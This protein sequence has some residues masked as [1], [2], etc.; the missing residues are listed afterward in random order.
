MTTLLLALF[1]CSTDTN[2]I[3]R[4][5]VLVPVDSPVVVP[6]AAPI[7]S[8][9]ATGGPVRARVDIYFMDLDLDG[10]G[11]PDAGILSVEPREGMVMDAGDC[12]D[13][14]PDVR[15]GEADGC[16]GIDNNCNGRVDEDGLLWQDLDGDGF[17]AQAV[18][19]CILSPGLSEWSGDCDDQDDTR[20]PGSPE[21]CNG[22]DDN[23]N[24]AKD[25]GADCG[26][27]QRSLPGERSLLVCDEP[28]PFDEA[29]NYCMAHGY[30]LA[31]LSNAGVN[32]ELRA[33]AGSYSHGAWWVGM[34]EAD[35]QWQW[36]DG[37]P[38]VYTDWMQDE[39][40]ILGGERCGALVGDSHNVASWRAEGC[41]QALGYLCITP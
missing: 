32:A 11:D 27:D 19:T 39:P 3:A 9:P 37:T 22:L 28:L 36:E 15:P 4:D 31:T 24:L 21:L 26:C 10:F 1:A 29:T 2:N 14:D 34:F 12:D 25:D 23:C 17:G 8:V 38:M 5:M 35:A 6:T 41:E 33:I 20:A 18:Q 40:A 13:R 30:Q 7:G 16:D